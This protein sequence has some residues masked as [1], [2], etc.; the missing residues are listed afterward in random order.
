MLP[1]ALSAAPYVIGAAGEA[2]AAAGTGAAID[3]TIAGALGTKALIGL[4][5]AAIGT[6]LGAANR[7]V[8]N[9]NAV[10][11]KDGQSKKRSDVVV[12][13]TTHGGKKP[14]TRPTLSSAGRQSTATD[15]NGLFSRDRLLDANLVEQ[16]GSQKLVT[17]NMK[18]G[19][20]KYEDPIPNFLSNLSGRGSVSCQWGGILSSD[21]AVGQRNFF[22]TMFRHRLTGPC[23]AGE[24]PSESAALAPA[25]ANTQSVPY[26]PN[27]SANPYLPD[28]GDANAV[29]NPALWTNTQLDMSDYI[30]YPKAPSQNL[31]GTSGIGSFKSMYHKH[32]TGVTFWAPLNRA[33]YEDMSWNLN[34]LKLGVNG[35]V[36]NTV[37]KTEQDPSGAWYWPDKSNTN[38]PI[39]NQTND[40]GANFSD[41]WSPQAALFKEDRHRKQSCIQINNVQNEFGY[42]QGYQNAPYKYNMC[43]NGGTIDY[44][45]M[46]KEA[47]PCKVT[48]VLYRVKKTHKLPALIAEGTSSSEKLL[49][50]ADPYWNRDVLTKPIGDGYVQSNFT[51][52]GTDNLDGRTPEISDI[53]AKPQFPFLPELK[54]TIQSNL[55][56]K[57]VMRNEF[58][59][60]SGAHRHVVVN[61]P[62]DIYD[63]SNIPLTATAKGWDYTTDGLPDEPVN[64]KEANQVPYNIDSQATMDSHSY[65]VV[66]ACSGMVGTRF[67]SK[68]ADYNPTDG[69]FQDSY[70]E[71]VGS[72]FGPF[73]L[74]YT[75]KYTEDVSG[76]L[77]K[78]GKKKKVYVNG[79]AS[80]LVFQS[81]IGVQ[82]TIETQQAIIPINHGVRIPNSQSVEQSASGQY[83]ENSVIY[84]T[85][86]GTVGQG[87]G[88]TGP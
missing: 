84:T 86:A 51:E 31:G 87:N 61:L 33:D 56:Y 85:N 10:S 26:A 65:M 75:C 69:V 82:P 50:W 49:T 2:L 4:G 34:K 41:L 25:N 66:I 24:T 79:K 37:A 1:A 54:R 70:N 11:G 22:M 29:P 74:Q 57:E 47:S 23:E 55:P 72:N 46:N 16:A 59:M 32:A 67:L 38:D 78:T 19:P 45:F 81:G 44:N 80:E 58:A 28:V 15:Y 27:P 13:T 9:Y 64:E 39:A 71:P 68:N 42:L 8:A 14:K 48:V 17:L 62:G 30:L 88:A 76:C 52:L 7:A 36:N 20:K 60:P 6:A 77:Y 5:D 73:N 40:I 53:W 18:L 12:Q 63:P 21:N 3:G 83:T 43:F 35:V